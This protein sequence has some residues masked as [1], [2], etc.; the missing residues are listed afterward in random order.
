VPLFL[1][2]PF[3]ASLTRALG[4]Q[5]RAEAG[6]IA[7]ARKSELPIRVRHYDPDQRL[8]AVCQRVERDLRVA[9][10]SPPADLRERVRRFLA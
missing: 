8:A 7:E 4:E 5:F 9:G 6:L 10:R 2:R 3:L 1:R